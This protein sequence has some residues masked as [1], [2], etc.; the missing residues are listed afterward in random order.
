MPNAVA[1]EKKGLKGN[2]S[3]DNHH[4]LA[5]GRV[6][7]TKDLSAERMAARLAELPPHLT[8]AEPSRRKANI[9][10]IVVELVTTSRH[11]YEFWTENWQ[12]ADDNVKPHGH[13]YSVV[14]VPNHKVHA[15]YCRSEDVV[16]GKSV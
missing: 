11:Q 5:S 2:P 13:L 7:S 3:L 16:E 6:E 12:G 15:Y 9:D 8:S 1:V 4:T 14:G 10:G